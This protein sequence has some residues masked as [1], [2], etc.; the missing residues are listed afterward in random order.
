MNSTYSLIK[1]IGREVKCSVVLT[2]V[3]MTLYVLWLIITNTAHWLPGVLFSWTPLGTLMLFRANKLFNLCLTHKLMIIHSF[4]IYMCCVYQAYYG[5]G[6]LLYPMR[7]IMFT[8]GFILIVITIIKY[9]K[10]G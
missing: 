2:D 7:I 6:N 10:K 4:L 8:S 1:K 5:F 9:N 3:I